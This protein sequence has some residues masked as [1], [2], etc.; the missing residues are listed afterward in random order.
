MQ[1]FCSKQ[2]PNVPGN[3]FCTHCGEALPIPNAEMVADRYKIIRILGQGGFGR[4]YLA[5]DTHKNNQT[6][7]LKEFAPQVENPEDIRKAKELFEREANVLK[8]LQ[9]AQIPKFHTSLQT[10]FGTKDFFFLVQDF[11]DGDTYWD[12]LNQRL[13]QG[14]KFNEEEVIHILRQI[15][16]VL[17]YLHSRDV[18]HRD[19]SP[20]NLIQRRD[21][22][23]PVLIDFGAVKQ[24][25]ASQGLWA[26]ELGVNRTLL[27]KKGYAPEEQIRQGKVF[28]C[29][30]IY[31]L[32]V[33]ALV[34]LTG[35]EPQDL[36]DSY[37]GNWRWG[38]TINISPALER[39]LKK[40]V[41]LKPSDRFQ[42]ATENFRAVEGLTAPATVAPQ[43]AQ[44]QAKPANPLITKLNTVLAAPA[45]RISKTALG[46]KLYKQS[47][48]ISSSLPI[49]MW[50]RPL[51]FGM[52]GT[53]AAILV[54]AGSVAVVNGVI[55]GVSSIS[56]PS[57]SLPSLPSLPSASGGGNNSGNSNSDNSNS[58][59]KTIADLSN[60]RQQLGI[61]DGFFVR[62][63]NDAFYTENPEVKGRSLTNNEADKALREEWL[64]HGNEILSKLEQAKLS[65]SSRRKIGSYTG[66]DYENWQNRAE[67]GEFGNY[68]IRQLN[69]DT[70]RKFDQLFPG[71]RSASSRLDQ[72]T[73][74]QI[75]YAIAADQVEKVSKK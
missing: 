1:V 29:S 19:I 33:T 6:C 64:K 2:H 25:P 14:Q 32:G 23:T 34:L 16:P 53:T 10:K 52:V 44:T 63:V 40:M 46:T 43:P 15:L 24:L 58:G 11:V 54:I 8:K 20:D 12:L 17:T 13:E 59:N 4:T 47:Q 60:R 5:E 75:W 68:T 9:H 69:T 55:R 31:S 37:Q 7:V 72:K 42:N 45:A 67:Q 50:L 57:I 38:G 22:Q 41:A 70:N 27:G 74:G 3:R 26:T 56:L 48:A 73:Y 49:P 65:E 51:A 18:I 30:D 39:V 61:S 21:N 66:Q 28:P 36:Y 71:I 62:T 35:K